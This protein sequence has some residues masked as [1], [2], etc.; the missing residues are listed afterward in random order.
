MAI[1]TR[2]EPPIDT[3][4]AP[5]V[6]R[7][8]ERWLAG[9]AEADSPDLVR[10]AAD[11][12]K[13]PRMSGAFRAAFAYSPFLTQEL[14]RHQRLLQRIAQDGFERAFAGLI[15]QIEELPVTS[16]AT[17]DAMRALR[18]AKRRAALMIALADIARSWTLE[19]VT[20][21]LSRLADTCL[22]CAVRHL[23]TSPAFAKLGGLGDSLVVLGMGK[24]GAHEL[25]YSSDI[26]LI[27]FYDETR[28]SGA[29]RD[30]ARTHM[31]RLAR[32]LVRMMDER[33]GDGYVFRTD[34]RLRPDPGSTPL[35][36]SLSAAEVYYGSLGQNWERA[37]MIKARQ[38]AGNPEA[39]AA[40]FAFLEPWIWRRHL[41]FAAIEDIHAIKRQINQHKIGPA[42]SGFRGYNVKLG[43]GG[44]REIE[45]FAQTQ[46]LIFGGRDASLRVAAT[47]D[48]LDALALAGR[49]APAAAGDLKRA[50]RFLRTLEHRL[51]MVDDRQTHALPDTDEG[52]A[53]IGRFLGF[54]DARDFLAE[55]QSHVDA[56]QDRF[57]ALFG[58]SPSLSGPGNLVFT[59][60]EDDPDTLRTLSGMGFTKAAS[61]AA[62]IRGWHHG[63]HRATRSE[64]AREILTRLIPELL[65]ALAA[66]AEPDAA[67]LRF[68]AFLSALPA[69]VLVLSL[70]AENLHLLGLL[71]RIMGM[72]PA[73]SEQLGQSPALF[74]ELLTADFFAPLPGAEEIGADLDRALSLA[75]D[76]EDSLARIRRWVAGRRFQAGVQVLEGISDG[77]VAGRFLATVAESALDRLASLVETEFAVRNGII[78][79]GSL[80]I[81]A[82]GRLGGRLMSFTSDLD[83]VTVYEAPEGASSDAARPIEA[84][85][86]F[87]RLT[88]RLI[89]AMTAPMAEGRLYEVDMRLRPSG[90]A[91]PLATS[92][93][94]F[95]RYHAESAWTWESMALTRARAVTGPEPLRQ[96]VAAV[97][98]TALTRRREPEKLRADIADMRRRIAEQ[99]R[100]LNRWDFKYAPGGLI[101]IEFVLQFL[102]LREAQ[103]IPDLLAT[104]S[105]AQAERLCAH[106]IL[107]RPTADDLVRA[108]RLCWRVQGLI[109]LTT[110]GP[111]Q[112]ASAPAAM[113]RRLA[114]E[115][116]VADGHDL[117]S[118]RSIDFEKSE[119]ILDRILAASRRRYEE[120]LGPAT[121]CPP[122]QS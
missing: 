89:T 42:Q 122:V 86:Y 95:A 56:V 97:I 69:G 27:V 7:G 57:A 121:V 41:D 24:L 106:G 22:R 83:L 35:A 4:D 100:P 102:L 96:A 118:A 37:A 115:V 90:E 52:V 46:Q 79:G 82:F 109:R 104:E 23:L 114:Q 16:M 72:A 55:L 74:D 64:R 61:I 8:V 38:V 21:A 116:A 28:L 67:F 58:R 63:R 81:L 15:E 12:L 30:E 60:V 108:L 51:Q 80:A 91:G 75:R 17:A 76:Y 107:Q 62:T 119:T 54:G 92:L 5:L 73:L 13:D 94:A 113:K 49:I 120:F 84:P 70:L 87:I 1:T 43:H 3:A 117:E 34:L 33:T 68:D 71:G 65:R 103:A 20:G 31:V 53:R 32:A 78:Q 19:T 111:F 45:F 48:A 98:R 26:D 47:C 85:P 36:V 59:G 50:Y 9:A 39:G 101:D 88:Q 112:P 77:I 6:S 44:I 25:N 93:S 10:F 18:Q 99:H 66:T 29:T 110:R 14:S 40:F 11:V 105:E 2:F